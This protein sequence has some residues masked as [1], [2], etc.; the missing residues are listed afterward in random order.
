MGFDAPGFWWR[1]AGWEA[2][3]LAPAAAIYGAIAGSRLANAPRETIGA[4]VL[5]VGNLTVGGSGKTPVAIALARQARA[6]GLKPGFLSRGHGGNAA[7]PQIVEPGRDDARAVGDEPLLLAAHAPVAVSPDRAAAARL[8]VARGCDF[9]VMDDGFQ[10]A[11]IRF[12]HALLV[13]DA[14]HGV[15]NGRVLP[16]G[17]LRAAMAD[18]L[19]YADAVLSMG[20]GPGADEI[21]AAAARTGKPVFSA[22]LEPL[23]AGRF[24][25]RRVLAFAGIGHP[26]KFFD[27]LRAAGADVAVARRFPDH[28]F[29]TQAELRELVSAARAQ[30]LALAT[31]AKDAARLGGDAALQEI[32]AGI[33]VLEVDAVFTPAQATTT[34]V[35]AAVRAWSARAT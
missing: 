3:A 12:D 18:Q 35:E 10:S 9:I 31:T 34:I 25:G 32:R 20:E 8:L 27:T 15:G 21:V 29:Y 28:H 1:P 19:R 16:A 26:D 33:E 30:D 13:V 11:R 5:C 4:P 7:A 14:R 17:P 2:A 6:M 24:A 22:A 23:D